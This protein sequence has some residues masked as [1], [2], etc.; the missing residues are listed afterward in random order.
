MK[1]ISLFMII[2]ALVIS[3]SYG[4]SMC[5]K[6]NVSITVVRKDI[7]GTVSDVNNTKKQWKINFDGKVVTGYAACN[8]I[9]GTYGNPQTNL[10][11]DATNAGQ[12]C[13]CEMWPIRDPDDL[14]TYDYETGMTSYWVYLDEYNTPANCGASCTNA[15]AT[16]MA[17]NATF[18][19]AVLESVW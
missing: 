10:E 3:S 17:T 1:K 11:T 12:H 19:S 4:V 18:R 5:V 14:D 9:E 6:N 15:C 2:Q 13:W 16:A 7:T 8:E